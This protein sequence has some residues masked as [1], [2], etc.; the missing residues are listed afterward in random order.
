MSVSFSVNPSVMSL[1]TPCAH[2]YAQMLVCVPVHVH[3]GI[4]CVYVCVFIERR[5]LHAGVHMHVCM[6]GLS[7][8][9]GPSPSSL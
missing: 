6:H 8:D 5:W 7:Q 4:V 9:P 1:P 3:T 2:V